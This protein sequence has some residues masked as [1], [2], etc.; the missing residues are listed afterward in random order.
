MSS[1]LR[2]ASGGWNVRCLA[3]VPRPLLLE[4]P[5]SLGLDFAEPDRPEWRAGGA[6]HRRLQVTILGAGME[7][8]VAALTQELAATLE[9]QAS[10][11]EI[12]RP[13]AGSPHEIEAV[14]KAIS[15]SA[16]IS[17]HTC[18]SSGGACGHQAR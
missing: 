11:S 6:S 7:E 3:R 4:S 17:H 13:I 14:F 8:R 12:L 18:C 9:Q 2:E 5:V 1:S 10:T 15:E 16:A